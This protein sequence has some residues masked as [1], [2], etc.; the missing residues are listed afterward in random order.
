MQA[1]SS[2]DPSVFHSATAL[3]AVSLLLT[4]CANQTVKDVSSPHFVPPIHSTLR[5]N[6]TI[7]IPPHQLSVSI[8]N[9]V[10]YPTGGVNQ[11]APNCKLRVKHLK[12]TGQT[13]EPDTF[14]IVAVSRQV[15]IIPIGEIGGARLAGPAMRLASGGGDGGPSDEM[16][17]TLMTLRPSTQSLATKLVCQQLDDP[18]LGEHV[19][20]LE[21]QTTLHPVADLE[22]P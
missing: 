19:S 16:Y 15:D 9:G 17:K 11:Y 14:D 10:V 8:Q 13:I 20:F 18:G 4:A 12:D 21:M 3:A 22:L 1:T 5:L 2:G 6:K 7:E